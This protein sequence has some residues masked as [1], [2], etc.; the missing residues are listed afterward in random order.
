MALTRDCLAP[1]TNTTKRRSSTPSSVGSFRSGRSRDQCPKR[2]LSKLDS[3]VE[4]RVKAPPRIPATPLLRGQDSHRDCPR[5]P[6]YSEELRDSLL[7]APTI[8]PSC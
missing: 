7:S 6:S 5:L 4:A 3:Y 1:T 2:R 8:W